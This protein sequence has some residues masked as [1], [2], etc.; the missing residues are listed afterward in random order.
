MARQA[1]I[2][3]RLH[4]TRVD[5]RSV[6]WLNVPVGRETY[7]ADATFESAVPNTASSE[8]TEIREGRVLEKVD[9]F[10]APPGLSNA[11]LKVRLKEMW[12]QFQDELEVDV[13]YDRYLTSWDG[14][15]NWTGGGTG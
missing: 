11:D 7:Y 10:Q 9:R 6:F 14:D 3:E 2:L 15:T 5:Y 13:T 8:L 1:I 12:Q 4:P